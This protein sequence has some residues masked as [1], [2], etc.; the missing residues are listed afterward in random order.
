MQRRGWAAHV[1]PCEA[2][3]EVTTHTH[4]HTHTHTEETPSLEVLGTKQESLGSRQCYRVTVAGR[5]HLRFE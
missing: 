4:T 1:A 2:Q 5:T 3:R